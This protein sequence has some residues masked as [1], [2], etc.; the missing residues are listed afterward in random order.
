MRRL[1]LMDLDNTLID[2]RAALAE[3]ITDFC[4]DRG[5]MEPAA[6]QVSEALGERAQPET[7]AVLREAL[8]LTETPGE[9]WSSYVT[10]MA[11]RVSC[12]PAMLARLDGLRA[13]G[14][15]VG[16]LTNGATDIQRAKLA[17]TGILGRVDGICISEEAG[18]RKPDPEVFRVA[19][20]RCG[21]DLSS[22]T[23]MV[24]DNP[25]TDIAG[26]A[27]AGLRSVWISGGQEWTD[28]RFAP[29]YIA[30]NAIAAADFLLGI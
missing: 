27:T 30:T 26:A 5:L 13:E 14:W 18:V 12:P 7:F 25:V 28:P 15:T 2:R 22:E 16:V 1:V 4:A 6:R 8:D 9:L 3:W 17:A 21:H 23:W 29:D 19:A 24:G 11:A 20:A 10:A